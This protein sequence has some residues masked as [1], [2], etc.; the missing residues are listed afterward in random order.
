[1]HVMY[2]H[3][4]PLSNALIG[5]WGGVLYLRDILATEVSE[6]TIQNLTIISPAYSLGLQNESHRPSLSLL[7]RAEFSPAL[8][9][10]AAI[11]HTSYFH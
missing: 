11:V 6:P 10:Q 3:W 1:M 9:D 7:K 4:V 2:E 5:M 8:S